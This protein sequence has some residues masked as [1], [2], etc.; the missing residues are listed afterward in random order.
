MLGVFSQ[1]EQG[2]GVQQIEQFGAVDFVEG[3]VKLQMTVLFLYLARYL[4]EERENVLGSQQIQA[5]LLGRVLVVAH[6]GVRL[7]RPCLSVRE[8]SHARF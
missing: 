4:F 5:G 3:Y 2:A 6:H 7:A 1:D 8:H